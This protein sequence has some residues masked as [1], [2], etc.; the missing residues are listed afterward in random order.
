MELTP[1]Q[2]L[3]PLIQG[4]DAKKIALLVIDLNNFCA[5]PHGGLSRVWT[6]EGDDLSYYWDR[7]ERV[8]MPNVHRLIGIFRAVGGRLLF[9]RAGAQF[10]D[11]ADTLVHLRELQ[12]RAGSLR[13]TREQD[14]RDDIQPRLGEAVLDKPGESVFTTGNAD[15]ILRNAGVDRI[16]ICG[17]VTNGCVML[18]ALPAFDLGYTVY[19][20]EDA[21][22][23]DSEHMH[24]AGLD[25]MEWLGMP[26]VTT[27]D[28]VKTLSA[29]RQ[30]A[31]PA[32]T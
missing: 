18:S 27:D 25:C 17:V 19:V 12:R 29:V 16:V 2:D 24:Q 28:V 22:A 3:Q 4:N 15:S 14:L 21:C 10:P 5:D 6:E 1:F 13:G 26:I 30:V 32:S 23:A 31:V 20:V 9:V 8:V 11:F 7:V